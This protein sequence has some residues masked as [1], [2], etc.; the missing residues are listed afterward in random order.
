MLCLAR[1]TSPGAGHVTFLNLS[2]VPSEQELLPASASTF[3][4]QFRV[5][6]EAMSSQLLVTY[7]VHLSRKNIIKAAMYYYNNYFGILENSQRY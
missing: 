7:T 5:C 4:E 2:V 3:V 6:F 1:S